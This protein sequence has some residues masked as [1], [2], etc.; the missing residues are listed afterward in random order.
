[1][2]AFMPL[3]MM[4]ITTADA[5]GRKAA[6][7]IPGTY[8]LN[9]Y[10]LLT[11]AMLGLAYVHQKE[12]H[13]SITMVTDRMPLRTRLIMESIMSV[14]ALFIFSLLVYQGWIEATIIMRSGASSTMLHIPDFPFKFIVSIGAFF[15]CLEIIFKLVDSIKQVINIKKTSPVKSGVL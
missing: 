3:L 11:F 13:V 10:M 15:L 7:N 9:Q 6:T 2:G 1:V 4:F 5:I 14:I 8:E 12:G